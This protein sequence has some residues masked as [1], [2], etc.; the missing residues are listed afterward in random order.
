MGMI[1]KLWSTKV[2]P[3]LR[4]KLRKSYLLKIKGMVDNYKISSELVIN[5]DQAGVKLVPIH[6]SKLLQLV[7]QLFAD[8]LGIPLVKLPP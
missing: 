5:W 2:P 6:M 1:I 4:L 8:L 7:Y 3:Q